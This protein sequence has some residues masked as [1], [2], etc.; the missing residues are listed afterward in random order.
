MDLWATL[1]AT[2]EIGTAFASGLPAAAAD[3]TQIIRF[4]VNGA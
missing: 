4:I 3:A 1:P 2:V